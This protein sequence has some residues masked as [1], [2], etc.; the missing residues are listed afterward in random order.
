MND[1]MD[2]KKMNMSQLT[3]VIG[4]FKSLFQC[5]DVVFSKLRIIAPTEV[6]IKEMKVGIK[7]LEDIWTKLELSIT[8]KFHILITHTIEQVI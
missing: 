1:R 4:T 8:P 7:V 2:N 6:E 3:V 5:M